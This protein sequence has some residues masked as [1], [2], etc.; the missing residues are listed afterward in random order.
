MTAE[1]PAKNAGTVCGI[2]GWR[3][4][5]IARATGAPWDFGGGLELRV[6][7][8]E[9]VRAGD[10]LYTIRSNTPKGLAAAT[11]AAASDAGFEIA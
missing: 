9:R 8:G 6:R 4:G 10:T 11:A 1:V 2:N 7:A 3:I 5:E